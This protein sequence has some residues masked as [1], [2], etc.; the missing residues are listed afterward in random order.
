VEYIWLEATVGL[1]P[2]W[3]YRATE[4]DGTVFQSTLGTWISE[5]NVAVNSCFSTKAPRDFQY[6]AL[7]KEPNALMFLDKHIVQRLLEL[8][9]RVLTF[10]W[11][12]HGFSIAWSC[13]FF[14]EMF[15]QIIVDIGVDL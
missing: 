4:V 6:F 8:A 1:D 15:D 11:N 2:Y 12:R 9:L 13:I 3:K 14:D 5:L 10:S 7:D